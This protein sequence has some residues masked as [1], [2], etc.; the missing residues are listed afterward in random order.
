M[1][2]KK[3]AFGTWF[4]QQAGKPPKTSIP[5]ALRRVQDLRHD[6]EVAES[7]LTKCEHYALQKQFALYAWCARD[8]KLRPDVKMHP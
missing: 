8:P 7:E 1:S 2:T 4:E 5:D 6:L 3:S